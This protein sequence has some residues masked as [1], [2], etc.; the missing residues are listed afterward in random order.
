M[1]PN[2]PE[3]SYRP[4]LLAGLALYLALVGS[5]LA[6]APGI[7][8]GFIFDDYP[9]LVGL[10]AINVEPGAASVTQYLLNGVASRLGRPLSLLTFALQHDSWPSNPAD[11]I[12]LN[13]LLHLLNGALLCWCLLRLLRLARWPLRNPERMA[14]AATAIWLISPLLSGAVLYVVQ[15][16]TLLAATC[17][18]SGFLLYLLG[19]GHL[20]QSR[21][22]LGMLLMSAGVGVGLGIGVLAK[23]NAA[24]FPLM[25]LITEFTLLANVPRPLGWNRWAGL[26]LALPLLA[27]A[28]YLLLRFPAD[29][30]TT[31]LLGVTTPERLLT[32][33]RVL[34]MYLQKMLMPS[35]YSIRIMYDDYPVSQSIFTPWTT[36]ASLLAWVAIVAIALTRRRQLPIFS[37]A[38]LW[39]LVCHLLESGYIPLEIAFDHRNYVAILGLALALAA[40]GEWL[41]SDARTARIRLPLAVAIGAYLGYLGFAQ[42]QTASLWGRP[43]E[44]VIYWGQSQPASSR[45]QFELADAHFRNWHPAAA[46]RVHEDGLARRPGDTTHTYGLLSKG[47]AW[48]GAPVPSLQQIQAS[49]TVYEGHILSTLNLLNRIVKLKE[50]G[51]CDRF[52]T[53]DLRILVE[54]TFGAKAFQ[55]QQVVNHH[56]ILARLH[57]LDGNANGALGELEL[58]LAHQPYLEIYDLAVQWSLEAGDPA[59]ANR[60]LSSA[61]ALSAEHP[62]RRWLN[63]AILDRMHARILAGTPAVDD[64][65]GESAAPETQLESP[66]H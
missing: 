37:W 26:F 11:F 53:A 65:P 8:G 16:M 49:L 13:V 55:G 62:L 41:L 36:W 66:R 32:E 58:S 31:S 1:S 5:W 43:Y 29:W 42:W 61:Q 52:S 45:V 24:L 7:A 48:A 63:S 35:L 14:I 51:L 34:F 39:F 4:Q 18:L 54:E 40:G 12:R 3:I 25:V 23:E 59:R 28:G 9:N 47:C 44:M 56:L 20:L 15:R 38:V 64:A 30:A 10:S 27:L 50:Q 33:P 21:P 19:R 57:Y 60:Y 2:S 17:M 6:Y 46:M 22:R